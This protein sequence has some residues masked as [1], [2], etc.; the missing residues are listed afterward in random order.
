MK[1][2]VFAICLLL[3]V[4]LSADLTNDGFVKYNKG[5]CTMAKKLWIKACYSGLP[6]GCYNLGLLYSDAKGVREDYKKAIK[7]HSKASYNFILYNGV[8]R[9]YDKSIEFYAKACI[10][11]DYDGCIAFKR[12]IKQSLHY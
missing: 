5:N 7:F 9:N 1:K 10:L 12:M 6:E 3:S 8:G 11:R 2:I 4:N